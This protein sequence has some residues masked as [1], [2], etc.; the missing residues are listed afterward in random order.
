MSVAVKSGQPPQ[1]AVALEH[2][3]AVGVSFPGLMLAQDPIAVRIDSL[4]FDV[5]AAGQGFDGGFSD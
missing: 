3:L 1:V 2:P 4:S 5:D